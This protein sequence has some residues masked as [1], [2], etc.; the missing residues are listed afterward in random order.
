ME[1]YHG[2]NCCNRR[3]RSCPNIAEEAGA[4]D[5]NAY[6]LALAVAHAPRPRKQAAAGNMNR[7][8][9]EALRICEILAKDTVSRPQDRQSLA[10]VAPLLPP[11]IA[12]FRRFFKL[13]ARRE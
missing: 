8:A 4:Y 10:A 1:G 13:T 11:E 5:A 6:G 2:Q 12:V 3:R 9:N 7:A